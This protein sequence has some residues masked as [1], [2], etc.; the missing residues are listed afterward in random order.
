MRVYEAV[1]NSATGDR[2]LAALES[3]TI[4]TSLL[5][6]SP[7]HKWPIIA[8][9]HV[10][11]LSALGQSQLAAT[12][13][14][15]TLDAGST[16]INPALLTWLETQHGMPFTGKY[17]GRM[18]AFDIFTPQSWL[19]APLPFRLQRRS[20][21]PSSAH[22]A[23]EVIRL[24]AQ[25]DRAGFVR[26]RA[27]NHLSEVLV[28]R[29]MSMDSGQT[30]S[31]SVDVDDT[32]TRTLFEVFDDQGTL[33]HRDECSWLRQ[34]N[35]T[36]QIHERQVKIQDELS[37]N[38]AAQGFGARASEVHSK[39]TRRSAVRPQKSSGAADYEELAR[40]KAAI[41]LPSRSADRW[42]GRGIDNQLAV[43]D[44]LKQELNGSRIRRAL[45]V[46]PFFG[47]DALSRLV[48]RLDDKSVHVT[49][50]TSW[51]IWH[52]DTG[53]RTD[54]ADN[55]QRLE[56]LLNQ[57]SPVIN[58]Q[59]HVVNVLRKH[60]SAFHD[61]YIV[62]YPHE[63]EPQAY[64]LSNS[65]NNLAVNWP[66]CIARLEPDVAVDVVDYVTGL[67]EGLDRVMKVK[68]DI[69]LNWGVRHVGI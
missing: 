61:R 17:A 35:L 40:R 14:Y 13:A 66:L 24:G 27:T 38:A 11:G 6:E 59:L 56:S 5:P 47:A 15:T 16:L 45:I 9:R 64:M 23:L 67:A 20:S 32:L 68:L 2:F 30:V 44:Y 36:M 29:L 41:A 31:D 60:D 37:R 53:S 7:T 52:P 42:F 21:N 10:K 65:I 69:N 39:T 19:D 48:L 49:V 55:R 51:G 33:L 22:S 25:A 34:M 50:V 28:D 1:V 62:L 57:A 18:G 54:E 12:I 4:D 3:G 63:G 8:S 43:I 26:I 58:P 46:D